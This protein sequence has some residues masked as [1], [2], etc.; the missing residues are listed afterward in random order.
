MMADVVFTNADL[1]ECAEREAKQRRRVYV[2]LVENGKLTQRFADRQIAMMDRI[3]RDYRIK[4]AA[5]PPA[6]AML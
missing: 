4:A 1:A 5:E 3:A 2:R 6:G